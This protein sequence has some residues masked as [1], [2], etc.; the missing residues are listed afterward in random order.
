MATQRL[1]HKRKLAAVERETQ[2]KNFRN[3]QS[4]D[5]SVPRINEERITHVSE[6][7]AGR[8]KK[9]VPGFQRDKFPYFGCSV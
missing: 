2:Q 3:G 9:S 6:E 1:K 7:I 5:T 8:L 4:R